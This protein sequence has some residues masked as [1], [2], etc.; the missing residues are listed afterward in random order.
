[1]TYLCWSSVLETNKGEDNITYD[2][3]CE[4]LIVTSAYLPCNSDEPTPT[5]EVRHIIDHCQ[6]RKKQL[7]VGCDDNA[8][9]ILWGS[10]GTNPRGESLMEFLVA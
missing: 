7:I 6:S 2:G 1:M 10:I 3:V 5:K 4:E 9:H 8:Q